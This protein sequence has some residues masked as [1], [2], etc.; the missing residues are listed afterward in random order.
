MNTVSLVDVASYLPENRVSLDYF[1]NY[2]EHDELANNTMFRAPQFRH[3]AAPNETAT[4][5]IEQA[6]RAIIERHGMSKLQKIDILITHSQLPDTPFVGC[7]GEVA[8]RL[9]I[10]P[11]WIIDLHNGG[12]ASFVY[13]LKLARQIMQSAGVHSALIACAQNC[14]G[15]IFTQP[16]VRKSAQ[17]A[18]PGDGAG[19]GLLELSDISP[20]LDIECRHYVEYAGEMQCVA[21]PPRKYW[22]PGPGQCKIGFTEQN[23]TKVLLRGSRQVPDVVQAVCDKI[24][25]APSEL[26]MLITN[27]PNR[28]FLKNWQTSLAIPAERYPDTF[29]HCGNLFGAAI[30][31]TLDS[32]VSA[33]QLPIGSIL[34]LAGFAHAGDFA[35]AAAIR[36]GGRR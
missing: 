28:T 30:P 24:G 6:C 13:M 16:E 5:M 15:Q 19:V 9:G 29:N 27:Q 33:G 26:G 1:L 31:V 34:M 22:Q 36:W 4:D 17:A 32:I 12:C 11:E 18:I 8:H 2:A 3:H 23:I 20:I 10:H 14:A 35:G 25:I 7:G 21:S